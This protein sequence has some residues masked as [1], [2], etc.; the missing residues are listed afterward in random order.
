MC[1]ALGSPAAAAKSRPPDGK[2]TKATQSPKGNAQ[3]SSNDS[4]SLCWLILSSILDGLEGARGSSG[5]EVNVVCKSSF[6]SLGL[7]AQS[8]G[9][10]YQYRG[11]N[12]FTLFI[13]ILTL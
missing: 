7:A 8:T 4:L 11:N 3:T 1:A 6:A 2:R 9:C 13:D 5:I 10:D 12:S